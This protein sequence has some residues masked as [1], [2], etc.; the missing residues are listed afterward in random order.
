MGETFLLD[1]YLAQH[2]LKTPDPVAKW[3][4]SFPIP[5][6]GSRVNVLAWR[7]SMD[8]KGIP[9]T[10]LGYQNF[11]DFLMVWVRPDWRPKWHIEQNPGRWAG[12]FAG[13]E[14]EPA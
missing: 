1:E 14:L 9:G 10:V 8:D 12:V 7:E 2:L 4:P 5:A 11:S 3:V 13:I 6:V